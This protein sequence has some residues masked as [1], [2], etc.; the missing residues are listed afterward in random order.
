MFPA[1]LLILGASVFLAAA[2]QERTENIIPCVFLSVIAVLYPFYCLDLLRM[3]RMVVYLL[4]GAAVIGSAARIARQRRPLMDALRAAVTPAVALFAALSLF[5][6][7]YTWDNLVGLWDELRLWGA[8]PKAIYMTEQLQVGKEAF[9]FRIMQSYPPGMPLLVYF[10]TALSPSFR[11]GHIFAT[12]GILFFA[13]I[14]PAFQNL[15]WKHKPLFFT[16]LVFTAFLPCVLTSHGGDFGWFYESLFIDPILGALAGYAFFLAASE[17]FAS[18]FSAFRFSAALLALTIIKDSGAMFALVAGAC[19]IVLLRTEDREA[20]AWKKYVLGLAHAA[21]PVAIGYFLW[22]HVLAQ[23]GVSTNLDNFLN[24]LPPLSSLVALAKQ[25]RSQPMIVFDEELFL[26]NLTLTYFPCFLILAALTVWFVRKTDRKTKLTV[27]IGWLAVLFAT[28][29][30]FLG[31]II[32]YHNATSSFQR[33]SGSTLVCMAVFTLLQG[34][35]VSFGISESADMSRIF[36][37]RSARAW[38]LAGLTLY[39]SVS[40]ILWR[41]KKWNMDYALEHSDPAVRIIL[42]KV[43]GNPEDPENVYLLISD[44]PV[45]Y[46]LAH[47]RAYFELLGSQVCVRNFWNDTNIVGGTSN[48]ETWTQEEIEAIADKWLEKLRAN[49]YDYVYIVTLNDFTRSALECVGLPDAEVQDIFAI[50]YH[51]DEVLFI[52]K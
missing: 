21:I 3:G 48:P 12:Y 17:P 23:H 11:E 49:D 34:G 37:K 4:I 18:R 9:V 50:E 19:A 13:L 27:G 8:V 42:D 15:K 39:A 38:L 29:L 30:F 33:Y 28:G 36:R 41:G 26:T 16:I 7:I 10:M 5:V 22:K 2:R 47:H 31:Y 43:E 6:C 1:L 45:S 24:R 25:L 46:S 52:K 44:I 20:R 51:G 14:L 32:S 40:L 35:Q